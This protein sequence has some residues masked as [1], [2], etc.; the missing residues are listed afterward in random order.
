MKSKGSSW[1]IVIVCAMVL[2]VGVKAQTMRG[3][4]VKEGASQA[5]K[6][7]KVLNEI[8]STPD[9]GIPRDLLEKAECVLVFPKVVKGGFIL[10][11]QGGRGAASCRTKS[12][13]SAPA[14]FEIKGGSVG[15]Q[16]GGEATDFVL[17]FMNESGMK[18][19]LSDKFEL[20]GEA[21]IAAGPVGRTSSASTDAK[22]DA[23]ILSYSRSKGLFGGVSLKGNVI[24]PDKS[25][26]EGTY[27][28]GVKAETVLVMDKAR[29]PQEVQ[30]FPNA[31]TQY[32]SR[33]SN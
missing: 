5:E 31:L 20:G 7:A 23:Q 33:A 30:V 21:S 25:D 27:G 6:S 22:M 8:M 13:W 10:G 16:I 14:Y 1:A 28:K 24:S 32:S 19:L 29:A 11:A 4:D 2:A 3:K 12:G 26:M 9:K 15:L 18:S 17:L